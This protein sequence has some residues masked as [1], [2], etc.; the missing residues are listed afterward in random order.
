MVL[1]GQD[2]RTILQT[3]GMVDYG[4]NYKRIDRVRSIVLNVLDY[5]GE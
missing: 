2:T 1:T 4:V 5:L 3:L